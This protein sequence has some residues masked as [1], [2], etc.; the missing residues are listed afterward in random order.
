MEK[1][2]FLFWLLFLKLQS[3]YNFLRILQ[4]M[5][6]LHNEPNMHH[7]L[8]ESQLSDIQHVMWLQ[9]YILLL[10]LWESNLLLERSSSSFVLDIAIIDTM[11]KV[12]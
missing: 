8:C 7:L 4:F 5:C 1:F 12:T 9:L 11:L 10:G 6:K 3:P 2:T